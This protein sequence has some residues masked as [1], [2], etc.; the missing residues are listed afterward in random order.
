MKDLPIYCQTADV[1]PWFDQIGNGKQTQWK[2]PINPLTGYPKTWN[3]L[4][5]EGS[6]KITIKSSP[7]GNYNNLVGK[8]IQ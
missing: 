3:K 7:S 8:A 6:I 5:Q 1:I 2:M 4:V